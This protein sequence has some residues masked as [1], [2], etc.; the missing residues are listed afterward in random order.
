M[1][2]TLYGG[3]RAGSRYYYVMENTQATESAQPTSGLINPGFRNSV[4]AFQ[5][6]PFVKFRGLELFGVLEQAIGKSATETTTRQ[7]RQY[8]CQ[9]W[10]AGG[11]HSYQPPMRLYCASVREYPPTAM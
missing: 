7:W 2:N 10:S 3:D 11:P 4:T 8:G 6:N 5:V 1:N 9:K